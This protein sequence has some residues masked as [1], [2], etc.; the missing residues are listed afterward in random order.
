M[1]ARKLLLALL[2]AAAATAQIT[3][4]P[5]TLFPDFRAR[6]NANF[7][8][9][10]GNMAPLSN[11]N[12]TGR[13]SAPAIVLGPYT[14]GAGANRLPAASA[15]NGW[16]S[17]VTDG[18]SASDCAV[19][20]GSMAALC[21]SNGSAWLALGGSGGGGAGFT[22]RGTY[23]A[24]TTYAALDM[25][26]YSG[27]AYVSLQSSNVGNTPSASPT[28][29]ASIGSSGDMAASTYDPAAKRAQVLTVSDFG[30]TSGT[31]ADG[32]DARFFNARLPVAHQSSHIVGG[33]D[34]LAGIRATQISSTDKDGIGSKFLMLCGSAPTDGQAAVYSGS[35]GCWQPG[36]A[37]S[38][39]GGAITS[40]FG[41]TGD[42]TPQ[43]GDYNTSQITENVAALYFTASRA[44]GAVAAITP[45]V[46]DA[47]TGSFSCPT[48]LVSAGTI[49]GNDLTGTWASP[50]VARVGG[51]SAANV[52]TGVSLAN[53]ATN[54]NTGGAI[55]KRDSNGDFAARNITATSFIGAL[56]GNAA[57]ATKFAT[58]PTP[59]AV[60][61]QLPNGV[62]E[63]GNS[64]N[65]QT[66]SGAGNVVGPGSSTNNNL[67]K[68]NGTTGTA[69][70]DSGVAITTTIGAT[71]SDNAVGTEK[72]VRSA[73]AAFVGSANIV[74]VGTIGTGVWHGT[75]VAD[76]YIASAATWNAKQNALTVSNAPGANTVPQTDAN[77]VL[78]IPAGV[79]TSG[80]FY[81][82]GACQAASGVSSPAAGKVTLFCDS[83][84][85]N[86]MSAKDSSGN[87]HDL[88]VLYGKAVP[89]GALVGTTDTQ[90][91][92]NKT[93][94]GIT[95]ALFAY[96]A[97]IT[98]DVQAQINGKQASGSYAASNASTTV[99]GQTCTLGGT[100]TISTGASAPT[101]TGFPHVTSGTYDAAAR[102]LANADLPAA[103]ACSAAG[104]STTDYTCTPSSTP[105]S[106]QD[107][108]EYIF[109]AD[110]AN[111][112]ASNK[113]TF[114]LGS[115]AAV[116]I[117]KEFG[118]TNAALLASDI[119]AQTWI[120]LRYDAASSKFQMQTP[121]GN[122]IANSLASNPANCSAGSY[123]LGI[124]ATGAVESCTAAPTITGTAPLKGS[125]GN[126]V[127]ATA[128]D[129]VALWTTCSGYLK[130]D[131]TCATP[132]GGDASTNT[133]TSVDSEIALFSS[134]GGK[135]LKRATG[136]GIPK[137]TSGV[138]GVSNV[139]DDAQTKA[140]V[141]PNTAPSA[142]Q[143]PVGNAGG[144]AYAPVSMSGDCTLASTGAITCGGYDSATKTLTNKTLDAEG[145]GNLITIPV[146][147]WFPAA[148]C[149][150]T[151]AGSMWDLPTSTP[152]VATCVTG[153]NTQKGVL[154]FADTTGGFSAQNEMLLPDDW[155]GNIDAKII[156]STPAT[157]GNA[158]WS[159]STICTSVAAAATDDPAFNTASTVTTA[160]P[161]SA[162]RLQVSAITSV[163]ATGCAAG[164]FLHIKIF[165]D[166]ND[167]ADTIAATANLIGVELKI[168]R[169]M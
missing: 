99:N 93:V 166:G 43:S 4:V 56:T 53:A 125:S 122:N 109:W 124:D 154:A 14:I 167:A 24:G 26:S 72:A 84:N 144:T 80:S 7:S 103:F 45:V 89:A 12:F 76:T 104:G 102:L 140:A 33:N 38:G 98:S 153:T 147:I 149:I 71:G 54:L 164:N 48:C 106:Y 121:P 119:R 123:P 69:L 150:N 86:H 105:G 55:V 83:S 40:V 52:A 74:T 68:F 90:T 92:T 29:W 2:I 17:V 67:A 113:P 163:T 51:Q 156:W 37:S 120:V 87:V 91:L 58:V 70:A 169:A 11:P 110:V 46:Y 30:T 34:V 9:I 78:N 139:T 10:S 107:G 126:A 112:A 145:T 15:A 108:E 60:N 161:G 155:T 35:A 50:A 152:A 25:V 49:G 39:G 142:G 158:K 28:Y 136:S 100:C 138:L 159:L 66:P 20:G 168:R 134:T 151:T 117:V 8:W 3:P 63:Y 160:A 1:L 129:I 116:P 133:S 85:S 115:L 31:V 57:T 137:I 162:N 64:I 141:V 97:N 132:G 65:C 19:G 127:A 157:S 23:S 44:R 73:I 77:G 59:C 101:G 111:T 61:G 81:A 143:F 88:D 96:L 47:A 36:A 130:S 21:R 32:N 148:G 75:A 165:R 135:T 18:T 82:S 22:S 118:G 128:A 95:P 131:G 94:D 41:R 13:I 16:I 5:N 146:A 42:V 79:S 6:M 62:D 27:V 114:K